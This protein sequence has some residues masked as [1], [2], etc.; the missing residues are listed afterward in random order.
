MRLWVEDALEDG[1]KIPQP[2]SL[3]EVVADRAV[4]GE[5]NAETVLVLIPLVRDVG[6]PK[7]ANVSLD[8]GTLAAIDDEARARGLTRS[9]FIASAALEKIH[10][11]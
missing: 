3:A 2:R 9:A 10:K 4:R 7:K 1:E 5:R 11:G 6:R 8:E